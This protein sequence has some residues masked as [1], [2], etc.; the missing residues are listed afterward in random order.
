MSNPEDKVPGDL[1]GPYGDAVRQIRAAA[2]VLHKG[3]TSTEYHCLE[4][5]Y[6]IWLDT[7]GDLDG[8]SRRRANAMLFDTPPAPADAELLSIMAAAEGHGRT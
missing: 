4:L 7:H 6:K 2:E 5:A 3:G 1:S 8:V